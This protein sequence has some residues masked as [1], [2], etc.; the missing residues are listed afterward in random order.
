MPFLANMQ[1]S[2]GETSALAILIGGAILLLNRIAS[3]RI[4]L[5]C[6]VGLMA[7]TTLFNWVGSDTNPMFFATSILGI[8]C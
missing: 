3:W 8:W 6:V 1:G 5:G 4:M 2:N 7:T